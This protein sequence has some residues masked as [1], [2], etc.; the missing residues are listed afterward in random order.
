MS[1]K[2][3]KPALKP[4]TLLLREVQAATRQALA[5][6]IRD[7]DL[8]LSQANVL[9]ELAYGKARS[10][11][12]LA[13]IQSVTPQTMIEILASLERRG[14]ISR[15]TKPDGGRT[16]PAELTREGHSSVLTVHRAMRRCGGK[17]TEPAFPGRCFALT[18]SARRLLGCLGEKRSWKRFRLI[19]PRSA[20][21]L[22]REMPPSRELDAT[23]CAAGRESQRCTI[24][25]RNLTDFHPLS[26]RPAEGGQSQQLRPMKSAATRQEHTAAGLRCRFASATRGKRTDSILIAGQYVAV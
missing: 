18:A 26:L 6:A 24:P 3:V 5:E 1:R 2:I 7:A 14:L 23:A 10:N 11:A 13:R 12:E 20:V 4:V 22:M 9:T 21:N 17:T 25:D 8:T 19:V 16:M 15:M